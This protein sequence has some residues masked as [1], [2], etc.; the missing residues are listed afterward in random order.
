MIIAFLAATAMVTTM[1]GVPGV[2]GKLDGAA[3]SPAE[4]RRRGVRH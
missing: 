4:P 2:P 3:A 1:A